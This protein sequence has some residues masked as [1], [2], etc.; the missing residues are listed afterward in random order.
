VFLGVVLVIAENSGVEGCDAPILYNPVMATCGDLRPDD[1]F[2][3][4]E[5]SYG[6]ASAS[7]DVSV[8]DPLNACSSTTTTTT[9]AE[10][11]PETTTTTTTTVAET[12][13]ETTTTTGP[14]TTTAA[15]TTAPVACAGF[16]AICDPRAEQACCDNALTCSRHVTGLCENNELIES[17]RCIAKLVAGRCS[18]NLIEVATG[19][20]LSTLGGLV[21]SAGLT[22]TLS[23]SNAPAPFTV[24]A[25]TNEAFTNANLPSL[26]A[27][28]LDDML[29]YHVIAGA[30]IASGDLAPTQTP[31]MLNGVGATV[32]KD[33]S[34]VAV[35]GYAAVV[36]A[37]NAG[38]EAICFVFVFFFPRFLLLCC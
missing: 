15:E 10:T 24:F 31:A 28:Q 1:G 11:S 3:P 7:C 21:Q 17:Y 33:G 29:K 13:P 20:G 36:A 34:S 35:N 25:P 37:D 8:M 26:S 23:S 38:K 27:A 9:G 32:T 19:A 18:T 5:V 6:D 4:I 16:N 14:T 30:N 2:V 12:S 22:A